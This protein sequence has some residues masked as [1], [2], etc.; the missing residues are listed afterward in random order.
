M[1]AAIGAAFLLSACAWGP[2]GGF[3]TVEPAGLE[4]A[5]PLPA[6]RL[7]SA[8]SWKTSSGYAV[9]L[10]GP[11]TLTFGQLA[12]QSPGT[13]TAAGTGGTFDPANPPPGYGLC[14]NGHCHRD[15]GALIPYAEIEAELASGGAPARPETVVSFQPPPAAIA[16]GQRTTIALGDCAPDCFLEAGALSRATLAL[17]RLQLAGEIEAGPG[18]TPLPGGQRAFTLALPLEALTLTAP[19]EAAIDRQG[20]TGYRLEATLSLPDR[21]FDGLPWARLAETEGPI[22]LAA[23]ADTRELLLANLAKTAFQPRLTTR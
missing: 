15:D 4:A 10:D 21:L 13:A 17:S 23:D 22:D 7:D 18:A 12:L 19:L 1:I 3:A 2:G 8:G 11:L 5:L 9:R 14:H 6:A 16:A 20:P